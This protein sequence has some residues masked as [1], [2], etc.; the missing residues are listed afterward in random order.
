MLQDTPRYTYLGFAPDRVIRHDALPAPDDLWDMGSPYPTLKP[1]KNLPPFQTGWMGFWGYEMLHGLERQ[2]VKPHPPYAAY[3][4]AWMG[5]Y[6]AVLALDHDQ[7]RAVAM[8]NGFPETTPKAWETTAR[9]RLRTLEKAY[10]RLIAGQEKA[11]QAPCP[12][13]PVLTPRLS[14]EAYTAMVEDARASIAAGTVYQV[15]IA[16]AFEGPYPQKDLPRLYHDLNQR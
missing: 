9:R 10:R 8:A 12:A 3:P 7:K 6:P 1:S 14:P 5:Y 16:Q 13:L 2:S 15:N 4:L 11:M